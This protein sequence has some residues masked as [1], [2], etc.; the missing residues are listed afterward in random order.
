MPGGATRDCADRHGAGIPNA[1][2]WPCLPR[3]AIAAS[4]PRRTTRGGTMAV[5]RRN[6]LP[7]L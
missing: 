5:G 6:E 2:H 1:V 4:A 7:E 3:S